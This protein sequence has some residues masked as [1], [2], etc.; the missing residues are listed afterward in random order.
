MRDA[1]EEAAA[2]VGAFW[3]VGPVPV[4]VIDA[5]TVPGAGMTGRT[6]AETES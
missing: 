1:R 5:V 3:T 2:V 4:V 6:H